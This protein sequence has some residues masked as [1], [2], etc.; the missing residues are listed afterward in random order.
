MEPVIG[1]R[2]QQAVTVAMEA[3]HEW[4]RA[5]ASKPGNDSHRLVCFSMFRITVSA[6]GPAMSNS[7]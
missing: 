1:E 3:K 4:R 2:S 5:S 7:R 6:Y